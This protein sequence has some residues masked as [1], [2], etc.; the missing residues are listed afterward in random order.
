MELNKIRDLIKLRKNVEAISVLD[1][2]NNIIENYADSFS[3]NQNIKN[4]S[5]KRN[6]R[7]NIIDKEIESWKNLLLNSD[8]MIDELTERK[9]KLILQLEKLENQPQLQAEKKGQISEGLR[10]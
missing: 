9:N 7:I 2:L 4:D 10:I 1:N 8:K 3:K 5:I 6:E